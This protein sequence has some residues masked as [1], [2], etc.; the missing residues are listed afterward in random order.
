MKKN[1]R[2]KTWWQKIGPGFITGAAD[3]DPSGIAT[4]TQVGAQFGFGQ[5]WSSLA[6]LPM[7]YAVQEM[8][9]RIGM[10]SGQGLVAV[11]KKH[12]SKILIGIL[13]FLL[14][15]ANTINIGADIGAIADAMK[16]M[17]PTVPFWMWAVLC[18]ILI[19]FTEIYLTYKT[20]ANIL[21]WL[22]LSLFSYLLTLI[23]VNQDW[24]QFIVN[25]LRPK[26]VLN[27]EFITGLM[28]VFGTTIS[29]YL[30]I[31]QANEE[32]EEEIAEG[33]TS[34]QSR[35]GISDKD[36][37]DM[38][39]DT[40]TGMFFSQFIML[41]IIGTA[42]NTFY[43]HGIFDI[44]T[45]A[46]AAEALQP[47]AGNLAALVYSLGVIGTGL[48]AIPILSAGASYALSQLFGW[49]EGLYK[50]FN[51]ARYFYIII[52]V[53]TLLGLMMNFIGLNPIKALFW[54]AVIN[55]IVSIPLIWMI[56][57][58]SNN[59]VIM[60]KRTNRAWSNLIGIITF[61]IALTGAIMMFVL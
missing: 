38:R 10:A 19:L 13:V 24:T 7:M 37:Q 18:C 41:C 39:Q 61:V 4:Y 51:Q 11:A 15:I 9:A 32:V 46:Q 56:L 1:I 14:V 3:D 26:I 31:W 50:K 42:A 58:I 8:V 49:E 53:A 52:I 16:L 34:L 5:L 59:R 23:V 21:K 2:Q 44:Q 12:Y 40:W 20:Y 25:V 17:V 43:K 57:K 6:L 33:K 55:G 27:K 36:L 28:A 29:P 48:M 47:L 22:G 35:K 54:A 60:G 45:T 30:F